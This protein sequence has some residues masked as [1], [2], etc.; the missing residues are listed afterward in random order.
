MDGSPW[1][2]DLLLLQR[3]LPR[4]HK[5]LFHKLPNEEFDARI[6]DIRQRLPEL[7]DLEVQVELRKLFALVGDAHTDLAWVQP[8]R[9][10]PLSVYHM[11]EGPVVLA[12]TEQYGAMLGATVVA[13]EG[14]P[15]ADVIAA[16]ADIIPHEN[17]SQL[18]KSYPNYLVQSDIL[19]VLGV[20]EDPSAVTITVAAENGRTEEHVVEPIC[21]QAGVQFVRYIGGILE[22]PAEVPAFMKGSD[23]P[24]WS[25]YYEKDRLL[26]IAYNQCVDHPQYPFAD[27]RDEVLAVLDSELVERV[28]VDL[29]RNGGGNSAVL[30]PLVKRLAEETADGRCEVFAFIGRQTFSSAVLNAIELKHEAAAVFVGEP[31]GGR[32]NH[33]GEVRVLELPATGLRVSYSTKYFDHYPPDTDALIPDIAAP[34]SLA[35][36]RVWEDPAM[37]AIG[38]APTV[39]R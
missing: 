12:A 14:M 2:S 11:A 20:V 5:D 18:L 29:R 3:K 9:L 21:V 36:Y 19:A 27:F 30:R 10:L 28:V 38:A 33:F 37:T 8:E 32:P 35:A 6:A 24:Y 31:S 26:Y 15:A 7:S 17:E 16:L 1:D 25:V 34:P 13:V 39:T 22:T 4:L 23:L